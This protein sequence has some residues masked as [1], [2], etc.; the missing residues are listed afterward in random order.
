MGYVSPPKQIKPKVE[1][2]AIYKVCLQIGKESNGNERLT[3]PEAREEPWNNLELPSSHKKLVQSLITSHFSTDKAKGL[4]F[5]LV[6][7]KGR[8]IS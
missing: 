5:D 6:R 7:D 2:M 4:Q 8:C 1:L 3:I